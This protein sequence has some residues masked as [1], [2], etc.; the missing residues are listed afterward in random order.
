M[1]GKTYREFSQHVIY[2]VKKSNLSSLHS[3]V[4][5]GADGGLAGSDVRCIETHPDRK[6]YIRGIDNH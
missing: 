1:Y 5:R 2:Y 6:V 4:D 3:L